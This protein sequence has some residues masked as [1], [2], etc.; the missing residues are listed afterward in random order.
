MGRIGKD[1]IM[2]GV[3]RGVHGTMDKIVCRIGLVILCLLL[4]W[5]KERNEWR[6]IIFHRWTKKEDNPQGIG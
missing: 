4:K 6:K 3:R 1:G 5:D 2:D